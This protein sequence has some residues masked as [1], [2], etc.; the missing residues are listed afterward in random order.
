MIK[1][2]IAD[3]SALMRKYLSGIFK[4]EG[5]FDICIA[6]NGIEALSLAQSFAPDVITLD[7]NMPAQ[8]LL[9]HSERRDS[10]RSLPSEVLKLRSFLI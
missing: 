8:R 7:V 2:L 9:P 10:L 5:D 1:L 6:R 4:A 3:D